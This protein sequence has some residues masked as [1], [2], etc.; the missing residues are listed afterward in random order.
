MALDSWILFRL[1]TMTFGRVARR[2]QR[3]RCYNQL[4]MKDV[5]E[6]TFQICEIQCEIQSLKHDYVTLSMTIVVEFREVKTVSDHEGD[7]TT[8]TERY[9]SDSVGV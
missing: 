6:E 1:E 7:G 9:R 5:D 4:R 3:K 8:E 2:E